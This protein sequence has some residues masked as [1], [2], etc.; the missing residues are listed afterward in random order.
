MME[1]TTKFQS[2]QEEQNYL[3]ILLVFS[4]HNQQ[5][6]LKGKNVYHVFFHFCGDCTNTEYTLSSFKKDTSLWEDSIQ[7]IVN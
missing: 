6:K 5:K 3:P 1:M 2:I 4:L 7:I